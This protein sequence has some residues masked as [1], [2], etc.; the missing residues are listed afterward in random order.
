MT[1]RKFLLAPALAS[2]ALAQAQFGVNGLVNGQ[3]QS[4]ITPQNL[5]AA[6]AVPV[7]IGQTSTGPSF[8]V[9]PLGSDAN[10]GSALFP[11]ATVTPV[12]TCGN[13]TTAA[14]QVLFNS[15]G[16]Y[17][18]PTTGIVA[19][20]NV[21]KY[22]WYGAQRVLDIL[23]PVPHPQHMPVIDSGVPVTGWTLVAGTT[24][25][26]A[27]T[28]TAAT[29]FV[30]SAGDPTTPL[31]LQTSL[32]NVESNPG[33]VYSNGTYLYIN[34]LDGSSPAGHL[35]E[36]T[37]T[38]SLAFNVNNVSNLA[39][40]GLVFE[41]ADVAG[42]QALNTSATNVTIRNNV[43]FNI[44]NSAN[45]LRQGAVVAD[46]EGTSNFLTNWVVD[47]NVVGRMD[48]TYGDIGD[49]HAGIM[50][51]QTAPTTLVQNNTVATVNSSAIKFN[52]YTA[53]ECLG[54]SIRDNRVTNNVGNIWDISCSN[55]Y[56]DNN[57]IYRS[58]G[59][60]I[61]IK[62]SSFTSDV[63]DSVH[64]TFNVI[65]DMTSYAGSLYNCIDNHPVTNLYVI[66]NY[67]KGCSAANISIETGSTLKIMAGNTFDATE[68]TNYDGSAI[69]SGSAVYPVYDSLAVEG[70][71][72][73]GNTMI[74]NGIAN[75]TAV[76]FQVGGS[77]GAIVDQTSAQ[78]NTLLPNFLNGPSPVGLLFGY[79]T[80]PTI[81]LGGG[82]GGASATTPTIT[83]T[84]NSGT[85][86]FTTGSAPSTNGTF[87]TVTFPSATAFASGYNPTC[88]IEPLGF[89]TVN[90]LTFANTPVVSSATYSG[91]TIASVGTAAPAS[92]Q[93]RFSWICI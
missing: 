23:N 47:S 17:H 58:S 67:V 56:I 74:P 3:P 70:L 89:A 73:Y 75:N 72:G 53:N 22:G 71:I 45:G 43:F 40:D 14:S 1:F 46:A 60:G 85:F 35:I 82:A 68:N 19:C 33:S 41:R 87:A 28:A 62:E 92:T 69:S 90:A 52:E 77:G 29:A 20:A 91:F 59:N 15:E 83:G 36:A 66:G 42:I 24:Y 10:I 6:P 16:T 21:G 49:S 13:F 57:Q 11:W 30:D 4:N 27:Y 26:A 44:G 18:V 34:L 7:T 48:F 81:V 76:R 63:P 9:S 88:H 50:L 61:Q 2:A 32:A 93:L 5:G 86:T 84:T 31:T 64:E 65:R 78:V 54:G 51:Y 8:F 37:T 55:V 39:I 38:G 25:Q 12:N 79:G 80:T